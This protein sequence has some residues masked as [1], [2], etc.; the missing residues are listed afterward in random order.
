[1]QTTATLAEPPS[2]R[3]SAGTRPAARC[4]L[5]AAAWVVGGLALFALF[6][7]ISLSSQVNSDGAINELQ[8]WDLLHGNVLLRG[9]RIADANFYFLELPLNAITAAVFGLG[10]FAA[11]QHVTVQQVPR[12]QLVDRAVRI[13]LGAERDP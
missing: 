10:N 4:W 12:L 1:M 6:L 8:A 13:H 7:R 2:D 9:W 11:Q 5:A 3:E